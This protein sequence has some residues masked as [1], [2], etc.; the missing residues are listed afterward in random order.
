MCD[1]AAR[2]AP[3]PPPLLASF[4]LSSSWSAYALS[5]WALNATEDAASAAATLQQGQ[6]GGRA[7]DYLQQGRLIAR[8]RA[9]QGRLLSL[10]LYIQTV[11]RSTLRTCHPG[12]RRRQKPGRRRRRGGGRREESPRV[13]TTAASLCQCLP[14]GGKGAGFQRGAP[15]DQGRAGGRAATRK[16]APRHGSLRCFCPSAPV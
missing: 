15:C 10:I 11:L 3:R 14:P 4:A 12:L 2:P 16:R 13:G 5:F 6:G 7:G 9:S 1:A 8:V